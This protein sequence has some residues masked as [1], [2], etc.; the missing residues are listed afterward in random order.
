MTWVRSV[1]PPRYF[2]YWSHGSDELRGKP[3]ADGLELDRGLGLDATTSVHGP[4]SP[5]PS[6]FG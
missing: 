4:P 5:K 1:L 2:A 6:C 3:Q